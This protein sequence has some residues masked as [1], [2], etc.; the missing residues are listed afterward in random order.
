MQQVLRFGASGFAR[1][2]ADD[3]AFRFHS[4]DSERMKKT[5]FPRVAWRLRLSGRFRAMPPVSAIWGDVIRFCSAWGD[6]TESYK[7]PNHN[8]KSGVTFQGHTWLR[9]SGGFPG[10]RRDPES[11]R[12]RPPGS[13]EFGQVPRCLLL[14]TIGTGLAVAL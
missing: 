9:L 6:F 8:L 5:G 2:Y 12:E 11:E 4:S 1:K 13:K 14:G 10:C 3:G 7:Q